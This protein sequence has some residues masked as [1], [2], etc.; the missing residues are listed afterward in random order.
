M[1]GLIYINKL[2]F[3]V[4]PFQHSNADKE[5]NYLGEYFIAP[6]YFDSI[7]GDPDNP[8]PN[9]IYAPRGS[10]KTA[11][12]V[13]LEYRARESNNI[14]YINYTSHDLSEFDSIDQI[15]QEYHLKYLNQLLLI[16]F[17]DRFVQSDLYKNIF[18]FRERQ[19]LYDLIK[20][21]LFNTPESFSRRAL[22]S[23]KTGFDLSI[24]LLINIKDPLSKLIHNLTDIQGFPIDLDGIEINKKL[25]SSHKENFLNLVNYVKRLDCLCIYIFVDRIDEQKLTGNDV[26]AS[27]KFVKPLLSD[28]DIIETDGIA[29]KFFL[30]DKIKLVANGEIRHDR[31]FSFELTWNS[32]QLIQM[33]NKRVYTYSNK[34]VVNVFE[35]FENKAS[36]DKIM[37]FSEFSP[38]DCIRI[39]K[40]IITEQERI[41]P[42]KTLIPDSTVDEAIVKYCNTKTKE[43]LPNVDI[44]KAIRDIGKVIFSADDL[45]Q[46]GI[47]FTNSIASDYISNWL[48][49]GVISKYG[50]FIKE[51]NKERKY[52]N[53]YRI[54]DSRIAKIMFPNLS[55]NDFINNKTKVCVTC[56]ERFIIDST[57]EKQKCPL[58]ESLNE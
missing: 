25:K 41:D 18:N 6:D 27:Y 23:L 56:K 3:V 37:L 15:T 51:I 16:S 54:I 29:F 55:I 40:S 48:K 7:W 8:V 53:L 11:Q 24:D 17:L 5:A 31:I 14:I 19:Y 13:M 44:R 21:Y 57:K 38:R 26:E 30:W 33:L 28:L 45:I 42:S 20:I 50:T 1:D 43:L 2:G 9:I 32:S 34:K 52:Y 49:K 58:C 12:K 39:C 47:A 35:L 10:G 46:K 22:S 4:D 36:I